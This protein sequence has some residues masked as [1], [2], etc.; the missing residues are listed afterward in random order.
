M[1]D[2][3]ESDLSNIA[4]DI[5]VD[6]AHATFHSIRRRRRR[7]RRAG[8]GV[9]GTALAA[10]LAIGVL[11][12]GGGDDGQSV[13]ADG[14]IRFGGR[15]VTDT[16]SDLIDCLDEAALI[17]A[18]VF[19]EPGLG[20]DARAAIDELIRSFDEGASF[21]DEDAAL[22]EV[23][24]LLEAESAGSTDLVEV[25][26]GAVPARF[27]VTGEADDIGRLADLASDMDGVLRVMTSR[28]EIA[29][30][31]CA[32]LDQEV[33]EQVTSPTATDLIDLADAPPAI[34]TRDVDFEKAKAHRLTGRVAVVHPDDDRRL[35]VELFPDEQWDYIDSTGVLR[36]SPLSETGMLQVWASGDVDNAGCEGRTLPDARIEIVPLGP[37]GLADG[38]FTGAAN[39]AVSC[40]DLDQ[41]RR[42]W[43][44]ADV[45][46]YYQEY[47][48]W[49]DGVS[50][51]V[52][53][54]SAY[55]SVSYGLLER[56]DRPDVVGLFDLI[57]Q[58]EAD[59]LTVTAVFH[60]DLGYPERLQIGDAKVSGIDLTS[61]SFWFA[62]S[63]ETPCETGTGSALDL[64]A[65][66]ATWTVGVPWAVGDDGMTRW[67]DGDGCPIRLDVIGQSWGPEHCG[68][69]GARFLN[70]PPFAD[71][72]PADERRTYVFDPD[73]TLSHRSADD[74][75]RR[76]TL[77]E[78]PP[79]LTDTGL[80][81]ADRYEIWVEAATDDEI[82]LIRGDEHQVWRLD[83]GGST[84]VCF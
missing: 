41:A 19:I 7:R 51:R 65:E 38:L 2:P 43:S 13:T 52:V 57:A 42:L 72:D 26:P 75:G 59:G 61:S 31:S 32:D 70:T 49:I 22:R 82:W 48:G 69:E 73:R 3:F 25:L 46:A 27:K 11:A 74:W 62:D 14:P 64:T 8:G 53:V 34:E 56:I 55:G 12:S 40:V 16:T 66:P 81:S 47:V 45:Q 39:V 79:G 68:M 71:L 84:F 54:Q 80:R 77:T 23:V 63:A 15:V 83:Q 5:D 20:D 78:R 67:Y 18:L 9:A 35:W 30:A 24:E 76:A 29:E 17:D 44:E 1:N 33:G 28:Q 10:A 36:S 50:T 6:A 4:P 21:L 58:S 60:P 37:I